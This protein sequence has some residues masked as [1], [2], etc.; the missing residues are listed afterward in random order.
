MSLEVVSY[1]MWQLA[2]ITL[3]FEL[4]YYKNLNLNLNFILNLNTNK[5]INLYLDLNPVPKIFGYI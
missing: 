5:I 2:L 3:K 1:D 4:T